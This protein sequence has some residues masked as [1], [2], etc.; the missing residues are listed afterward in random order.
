MVDGSAVGLGVGLCDGE[1][2]APVVGASVAAGT[3]RWH[4]LHNVGQNRDT[5]TPNEGSVHSDTEKRRQ[6]A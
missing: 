6:P 1:G 4:E 5:C 3:L 2:V